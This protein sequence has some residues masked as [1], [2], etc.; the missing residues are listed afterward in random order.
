MKFIKKA[1]KKRKQFI[2]DIKILMTFLQ[3]LFSQKLNFSVQL[4]KFLLA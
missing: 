4:K 2:K 1:E 3:K